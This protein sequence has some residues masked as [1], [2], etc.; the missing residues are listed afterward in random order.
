VT[1]GRS[2]REEGGR[3]P[4]HLRRKGGGAAAGAGSASAVDGPGRGAADGGRSRG[5]AG[6]SRGG[7]GTGGGL[8]KVIGV[9]EK[10]RKKIDVWAPHPCNWY[11]GLELDMMSAEET[12]IEDRMTLAIVLKF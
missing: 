7:G 1:P 10:K 2:R 12:G 6:G 11:Q 8:E 3:R 4:A 5:D 9:R